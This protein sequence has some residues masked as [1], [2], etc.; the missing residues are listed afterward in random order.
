MADL[1]VLPWH[2]ATNR[3]CVGLCCVAPAFSASAGFAI[4]ERAV[5]PF[6]ATPTMPYGMPWK[7]AIPKQTATRSIQQR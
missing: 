2:S 4:Q 5:I 1:E 7:W 3:R 6:S